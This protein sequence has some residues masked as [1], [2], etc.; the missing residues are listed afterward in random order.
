MLYYGFLFFSAVVAEKF[1]DVIQLSSAECN[2]LTA[3]NSAGSSLYQQLI[4]PFKANPNVKIELVLSEVA[5]HFTGEQEAVKSAHSH[6]R[7][8]LQRHIP[9]EL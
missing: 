3:I 8:N 9:I 7:D 5:V 4:Q 2:L 6:F 1:K